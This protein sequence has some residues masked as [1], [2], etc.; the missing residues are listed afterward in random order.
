M[1]RN[2]LWFL[3]NYGLIIVFDIIELG[4][5]AYGIQGRKSSVNKTYTDP[6]YNDYFYSNWDALKLCLA[7]SIISLPVIAYG[8][9]SRLRKD[10]IWPRTSFIQHKFD[11]VICN[12]IIWVLWLAAASAQADFVSRR[13][14]GDC[15][16]FY[17]DCGPLGSGSR[18]RQTADTVFAF[19]N[20]LAWW[21]PFVWALRKCWDSFYEGRRAPGDQPE[22]V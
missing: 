12:S 7:V 1:E 11:L 6:Y 22:M 21:G 18:G 3:I 16:D 19:F 10:S 4:L 5:T 20:W 13:I 2:D 8:L 14:Y 15:D 17:F 9:V